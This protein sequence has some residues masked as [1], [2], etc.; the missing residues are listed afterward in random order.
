MNLS[1]AAEDDPDGATRR[2]LD[3]GLDAFNDQR[4]GPDDAQDLWVIARDEDCAAVAGLKARTAYSWMFIDW[5]WVSS[6]QRGNGL[7]KQLLDMAEDAAR[8]RGCIGAYVDTYS[9][10]APDF[11]LKSGYE[12]FGRIDDMPPGH[13]C[14]WLRKRWELIAGPGDE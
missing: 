12:E 4:A 3:E 14:I 10:Q 9:F 8:T 13:S 1:V 11:Y 5:L 7:G 2:A 6:E